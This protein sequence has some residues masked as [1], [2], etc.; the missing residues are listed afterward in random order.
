MNEM[1]LILRLNEMDMLIGNIEYILNSYKAQTAV[2][3][4]LKLIEQWRK[5]DCE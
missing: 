2:K 3:K 5:G 1:E 4:A